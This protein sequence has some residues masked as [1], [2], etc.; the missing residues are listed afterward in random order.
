MPFLPP[1]ILAGLALTTI[2]LL[3]PQLRAAVERSPENQ[4]FQWAVSA[5]NSGWPDG[6]KNKATL[7]LWIP[8]KTT[9]VRGVVLMATN[10][11]EHML[12]GHSAIRRACA[13]NNLALV[14]GVP[15]FW[16]FGKAAPAP[17]GVPV[18]VKTLPD[19]DGIQAAFLEKLLAALAEKSGYSELASVPWLP[20]GESGHLLM[21]VGLINARP[22][23]VVAGICVKNPHSPGDK[24]VPLLWTL[25]T[26]QEWA[27]KGKDVRLDWSAVTA[28]FQGWVRDRAA[29]GWPLSVVI[30]PGTG[31]FFCTDEMA[32]Y[33]ARYLDAAVK[34]R[35]DPVGGDKLR[36][37]DLDAGYLANLPLPGLADQRVIPYARATPGERNRAWF[38]TEDL[39]RRAQELSRTNW[40]A[41][42]QLVGFTADGNCT[43][44]PFTFNSVTEIKVQT[45]G[46][47]GV[48]AHLLDAIPEGFVG[49][50]E[51]LSRTPGKPLVEWICGPFAP[52]GPNRFRVS[53]DRTWRTGAA[54]YLIARQA[55]TDG[56]RRSVQ[57]AMVRLLE[58]KEGAPQTIT[59]EPLGP[60]T[61]GST[62]VPLVAASDSDL[63]VSFTVLS[64]PAVVED[65]ELVFTP[66]PP[67]ARYPV[68]VTVAAWQWGRPTDPKI[69]T[70][71]FV[72]QTL[73]IPKP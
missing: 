4:V 31:H 25:G 67:R 10:V 20:V 54:A 37:P 21:V 18:D 69:R 35:L 70:A 51:K 32:E 53:L 68:E 19:S 46:E 11:P 13:E 60:V 2:S 33:F 52:A 44:N 22:D 6:T 45:D 64:G 7:Y 23:R 3:P 71:D 48:K 47:F 34:A 9:R 39:A 29:A 59:F 73:L 27:Q 65:G 12:V 40:Q 26:G 24:T 50:G 58:N 30:E 15:T 56:V 49:A 41:E 72:T 43:V 5:E 42:T 14:W 61:A 63:P 57:P 17:G 62:R 28:P 36:P 1:R 16:R 38:F 55:A 8:E 66:I